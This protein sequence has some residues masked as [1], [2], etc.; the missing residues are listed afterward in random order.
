[1]TQESSP[2]LCRPRAVDTGRGMAWLTEGFD[3]FQ[4][5]ALAWLGATILLFVITL[6]LASLPLLGAL[7]GQILMP[8]FIG[9]M[10]LGCRV[11]AQGGAFQVA[12]LFAGFGQYTGQLMILGLLYMAG[13][14][15]IAILI[16]I[17]MVV[18]GVGDTAFLAELEAGDI[19]ALGNNLKFLL[20]VALIGAALYAPLLMA[21]WFAPALVILRN[22]GAI[23]AMKLSFTG[24]L[25]NIMPFLLYGIIGLVLCVVAI[26]PMGLGLLVLF[27]VVTA[28]IYVACQDIYTEK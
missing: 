19:A 4:K 22:A 16:V 26:I 5:D 14:I 24:S 7:A 17:L 10:M 11:R 8:V 21:Y 27:P 13:I 25:M 9:G 6:A 28:S 1:M 2:N 20:L 18:A 12:H 23:D 3:Y 15:A